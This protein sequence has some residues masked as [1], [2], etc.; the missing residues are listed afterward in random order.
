M[1]SLDV[2]GAPDTHQSLVLTWYAEGDKLFA[3]MLAAVAVARQS[4]R[5]E[6]YIFEAAGIGLRMRE[7]LA[8]AASRGV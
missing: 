3:D 4:V 6:T 2:L 5:L 8:A 1:D 7:S